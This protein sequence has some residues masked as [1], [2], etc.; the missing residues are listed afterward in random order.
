[1]TDINTDLPWFDNPPLTEVAISVQFESIHGLQAPQI[2]LLWSKFRKKYPITEQHELIN[3]VLEKFDHPPSSKIQVEISQVT[4]TPRCWFLNNNGTELIQVQSDRFIHNWRKID[5]GNDYPR[6]GYIR[7]EFSNELKKFCQFLEEEKLGELKPIQCEISY[8]NHIVSDDIWHKHSDLGKIFPS[9]NT[10]YSDDFLWDLENVRL[11]TQHV[12]LNE[13][14][15]PWGRLH[16]SFNPAFRK[17]DGSPMYVMSLV[18]RGRPKT[19]DMD[20]VFEFLDHGR[21]LIVKSFASVTSKD[22][23]KNIWRRC[24]GIRE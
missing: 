14:G 8:V 9:W 1:M 16:I 21:E 17:E 22:M 10:C 23:H 13:H 19:E 3:P 24:D 20:G 18:A 2:G 7:S 12:F 11:A 4:P 6:Y 5:Q 15:E